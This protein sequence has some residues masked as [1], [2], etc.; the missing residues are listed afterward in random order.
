M[1]AVIADTLLRFVAWVQRHPRAVLA[2]ILALSILSATASALLL[3]IDGDL[4]RLIQ[5]RADQV[6]Y[7][8]DRDFKAAFPQL[9]Q[10]AMVVV[11]GSDRL[12][13]VEHA[14]QLQQDLLAQ[15]GVAEVFAPE[16]HPFIARRQFYY[17][18]PDRMGTWLTAIAFDPSRL[19]ALMAQ[20]PRSDAESQGDVTLLLRGSRDAQRSLPHGELLQGLRQT[21]EARPGPAGVETRLTGEI[22]L[23]DEE[24]RSALQGIGLAGSVS[25]ALLALILGFG[26][27]CWRM[28]VAIFSLLACGT[29]LTLGWG[30]LAIGPFNTLALIFVV[31]FFGLGVDFAVHFGLRV[32]EA[33]RAEAGRA[34]AGHPAQTAAR[35]IGPAL[36]L[37]LLTTSLAF[38]AFSP[39]AYRGLAELGIVSAGGMVIAFLLTL[40]LL[41]ALFALLGPPRTPLLRHPPRSVRLPPGPVVIGMTVIALGAGYLAKDLRFDYSVLALRDANTEAMQTLLQRQQAGESTDYSIHVL[42]APEQVQDLRERLEALPEVRRVQAPDDW[43]PPQQEAV[44]EQLRQAWSAFADFDDPALVELHGLLEAEPFDLEDL[45][46]DLRRW[47]IAADG[48]HLLR[49]EPATTLDDR[50]ALAAFVTAVAGVAPNHA[51]RAVVEWGVGNVVVEAFAEAAVIALL[52]ISVLLLLYFRSLLLPLLVLLPIS[53]ALL[54][55]FAIAVVTN[56]S[57]NMAN[58]LVVPLIFGLGVDTGIHVIHRYR[59]SGQVAAVYTSSTARAV[60]ISGL[61]T[62]GTFIALAFSPH[63]GAASVGVLLAIAIGAL[64]LTTFLLLPALLRLLPTPVPAPGLPSPAEDR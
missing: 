37:C 12:A 41:P 8:H 42:A 18:P 59:H 58:I 46:A 7:Q 63:A 56:L 50:A 39:T 57:L 11:S 26:L 21:L 1:Q 24:I 34:E 17:L 45:P 48:R 25:L 64:L 31:M 40:T 33:G 36:L 32:A 49:V 53:L 29:A 13:M 4:E 52:G 43:I 2:L 3:R 35:E 6:W 14:R 30:I 54:L 19:H 47:L 27:R 51:G 16:L 22:V 61:T 23:E 9:Q 60:L 44:H 38:L 62:V 28:A 20:G 5:P 55:T 10:T 15:P